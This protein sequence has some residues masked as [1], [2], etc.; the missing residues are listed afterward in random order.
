MP[1]CVSRGG[2]IPLERVEAFAR[3]HTSTRCSQDPARVAAFVAVDESLTINGGAPS[4]GRPVIT[5]AA[6]RFMTAFPDRVADMDTVERAGHGFAS[7]WSLIN[8]NSGPGG[9]V[10][11][12]RISGYEEWALDPGRSIAR[13]LGRFDGTEYRRQ[14]GITSGP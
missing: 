14:L 6:Q 8:T 13:S 11:S 2:A 10:R 4:V 5:A 12:V 1:G 3:R 7:R 9:T